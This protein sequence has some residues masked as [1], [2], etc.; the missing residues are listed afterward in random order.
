M[1]KNMFLSQTPLVGG[2]LFFNLI[3][4]FLVKGEFIYS[5]LFKNAHKS[6]SV[7]SAV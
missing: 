7:V 2:G 3:L 5:K 4:G 6:E 1:N